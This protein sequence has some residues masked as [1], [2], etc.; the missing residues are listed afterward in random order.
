MLRARFA[1]L[2][3]R[4]KLL[5]LAV[6]P[7]AVAL[8]LLGVVA[9]LW[10]N[11]AFD[12][13]LVTKVRAD[14]AVAHG[15]FERVLGEVDSS[16]DAAAQSQGLARRLG[17][18]GRLAEFL[19]RHKARERLDFLELR[20]PQGGLIASSEG[21]LAGAAVS[22]ASAPAARIELLDP[23][24]LARVAPALA[25]RVAVPLVPTRNAAPTAREG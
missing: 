24:Q 8:P 12:Q 22:A 11:A 10:A 23:A 20:D 14:L 4:G 9:L 1:R 2:P 19:I 17:D 25:S 6:L 3:I 13:L 16:V 21:E 18:R 15:Y 5:V 7:M